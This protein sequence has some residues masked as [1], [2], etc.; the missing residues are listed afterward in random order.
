MR[1]GRVGAGEGDAGA[2]R[3]R[4]RRRSYAGRQIAAAVE[5]RAHVL[6]A[7]ERRQQRERLAGPRKHSAA[8]TSLVLSHVSRFCAMMSVS[9]WLRSRAATPR[10]SENCAVRR[11]RRAPTICTVPVCAALNVN[12]ASVIGRASV[13]KRA[14]RA[15][16]GIGAGVLQHSTHPDLE[17]V[18]VIS[19][20]AVE[21]EVDRAGAGRARD[22]VAGAAFGV[23]Q[24]RHRC[25]RL[26]HRRGN[27]GQQGKGENE[28]A[29]DVRHGWRVARHPSAATHYRFSG[30]AFISMPKALFAPAS[31][32]LRRPRR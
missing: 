32:W 1:C 11:G 10:F 17:P 27:P 25:G 9:T 23:G 29:D 18:A 21:R 19:A 13:A 12:T 20:V 5:A 26:G 7:G 4:R 14:A 8:L 6:A 28:A 3:E 22:R 2:S 30:L 24:R 31:T 15:G 16:D